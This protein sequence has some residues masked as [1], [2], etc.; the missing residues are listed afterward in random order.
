MSV[1]ETLSVA[2]AVWLARMHWR[3]HA[4]RQVG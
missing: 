3:E 2:R 4:T 1:E